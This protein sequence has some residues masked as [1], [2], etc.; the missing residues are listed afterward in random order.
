MTIAPESTVGELVRQQPSRSRVFE[1]LGIDYCCGGKKPLAQVCEKKGL[2]VDALI[3]KLTAVEDDRELDVDAMSLSA[4]ANL[5]E[6][7]HHAFLREE[8]PR[9]MKMIRKVH[10]VHG[11][12]DG[13]LEP[14]ERTFAA[15]EE[16]I[17]HHI[18]KEEQ[19]LFP[20]IRLLET[21]PEAVRFPGSIASPIACMESE[22]D[23]AGDALAQMRELT[24]EFTPADYACNTWRAMLDGLRELESDM[25][26]HVHRENNVLFPKALELE[27]QLKK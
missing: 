22:H 9:L 8:L 1:E 4:L 27:A 7:T 11:E 20:I 2:D 10:K 5:I 12:K 23:G 14:L 26:Q 16:E 15:F 24:D 19:I 3:E 18:G 25:H 17:Y 21:N 13:R 6:Q